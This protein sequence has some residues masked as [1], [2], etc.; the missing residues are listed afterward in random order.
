[1]TDKNLFDRGTCGQSPREGT[2]ASARHKAMRDMIA[3][4]VTWHVGLALRSTG[5]TCRRRTATE[6]EPADPAALP[7]GA[8]LTVSTG[9][10]GGS[11]ALTLGEAVCWNAHRACCC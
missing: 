8:R 4:N 2:V 6:S 7:T 9:R 5:P 1:M 10:V 3:D 11:W